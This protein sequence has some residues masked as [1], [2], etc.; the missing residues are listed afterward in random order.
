[1]KFKIVYS[2]KPYNMLHAEYL[3]RDYVFL[4]FIYYDNNV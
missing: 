1:M 3:I 2:L 4:I